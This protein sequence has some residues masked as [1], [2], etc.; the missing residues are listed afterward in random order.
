MELEQR[1]IAKDFVELLNKINYFKKLEPDSKN[2]N[3]FKLSLKIAS[4]SELNL[5]IAALL[6]TSICV[7]KD[8]SSSTGIDVM[9][10]LEMALQ[11]LPSDE[12]ELLDEIYG[13]IAEIEKSSNED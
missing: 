1:E 2:D 10:L 9:L 5:T 3:K 8:D 12:M 11:M 7:L 6:K 4:Y 13:N